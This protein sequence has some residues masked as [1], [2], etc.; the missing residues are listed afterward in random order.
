[1]ADDGGDA[2]RG[3]RARLLRSLT[4]E[5]TTRARSLRSQV[6]HSPVVVDRNDG[7]LDARAE[8]YKKFGALCAGAGL[9]APDS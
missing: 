5:P 4:G 1:M 2:P 3:R 7:Q 9:G 8:F 6:I